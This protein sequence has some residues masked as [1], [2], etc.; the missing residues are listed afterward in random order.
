MDLT[1]S[2]ADNALFPLLHFVL[3]DLPTSTKSPELD[4]SNT[5]KI[6]AKTGVKNSDMRKLMNVY[7]GYLVAV[8]FLESPSEST[9]PYLE[10]WA[11]IKGHVVGRSGA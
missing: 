4:D 11:N 9:L 6:L 3:D 1:L 10:S 8:G 7:L 2:S 5:R